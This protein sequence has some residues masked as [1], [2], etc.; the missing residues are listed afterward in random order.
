MACKGPYP[1]CCS[2]KSSYLLSWPGLWRYGSIGRHVYIS[3]P[4][5]GMDWSSRSTICSVGWIN[6]SRTWGRRERSAAPGNRRAAAPDRV[7]GDR[8]P[9]EPITKLAAAQTG[10]IYGRLYRSHRRAGMAQSGPRGGWGKTGS[11]KLARLGHA[12][13]VAPNSRFSRVTIRAKQR[14]GG[15]DAETAFTS[16]AARRFASGC[17]PLGASLRI[18]SQEGKLATSLF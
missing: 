13:D 16:V 2:S 15:D 11:G 1:T 8:H 18:G 3:Q 10:H 12:A 9:L 6:G 5:R 17:T 7:A 14:Y 4:E